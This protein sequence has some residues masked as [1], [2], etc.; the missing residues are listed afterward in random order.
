VSDTAIG[1]L[2][3]FSP[4]PT[5]LLMWPR[6]RRALVAPLRAGARFAG[7]VL[8]LVGLAAVDG[9]TARATLRSIYT[10]P[11]QPPRHARAELPAATYPT[12]PSNVAAD[13]TPLRGVEQYSPE[14]YEVVYDMQD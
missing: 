3:L 9:D 14:W 8:A 4:I 1:A 6:T 7:L 10:P 13:V 5:L 2:V 12:M 11:A